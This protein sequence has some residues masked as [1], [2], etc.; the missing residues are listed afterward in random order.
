MSSMFSNLTMAV[1]GIG[2]NW[3]RTLLTMLGVLIGVASV[4][5]LLAIGTGTSRSIEN[6][7]QALGSNT[8]TVFSSGGSGTPSGTQIRNTTLNSASVSLISNPN[9]A[10]DVQSVSPVITTSVTATNGSSTYSTSVVGSTPSYLVASNY[11][12]SAGRSISA[13]DVSSHSQV[14][15]LGASVASG[16]FP[17]GSNPLGQQIEL[18]SARFTIV[19]LL[20]SKGTTGLT[21]ADAVAIAPYTAVQDQLTGESQSFS[22]LLIQGKSAATLSLAQSEVQSILAAQN[23]TTVAA[24]P[25]NV[26]NQAS[27]ITTATSSS[28]TFTALLGWVAA[29]SLLVGAIGVMNIM[30]VTVTERTREIGIRKAIGAPKSAI[31]AQFLLEAVLLSLIGGGGGVLIGIIGTHFK[32]EG[33]TPVI[34]GYSIPLAF[35]IAIG[36][37]IFFGLYPA[38]RA[39]SLRPIDALRY[40]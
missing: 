27:L 21:N 24:L 26:L 13:A 19:G 9:N 28:K 17:V 5:V 25:F 8:L 30:L 15:D 12:L 4:I 11:T 40:E 3:L 7:I 20:A 32:I 31:L 14:V 6:S 35:G 16:L 22:E 23:D 37:G 29:V 2:S 36:V 1:R 10:P 38:N 34:A 33:V 18:G 39:A